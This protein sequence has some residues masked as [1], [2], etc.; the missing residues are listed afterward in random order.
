[1]FTCPLLIFYTKNKKKRLK[2]LVS[3]P[4]GWRQRRRP[5]GDRTRSRQRQRRHDP[6]GPRAKRRRGRADTLG[7]AGA[8]W[9]CAGHTASSGCSGWG[10]TGHIVGSGDPSDHRFRGPLA[11][12]LKHAIEWNLQEAGMGRLSTQQTQEVVFKDYWGSRVG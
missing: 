9:D 8:G 7:G 11:K 3:Q 4:E 1:M 2:F 12:S 10:C 6:S 5:S